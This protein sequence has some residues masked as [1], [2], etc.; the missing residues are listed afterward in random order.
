MVDTQSPCYDPAELDVIHVGHRD[1]GRRRAAASGS[2]V[3]MEIWT[4]KCGQDEW[5]V[6][7]KHM[8]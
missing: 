7:P 2:G 8:R 6:L 1:T 3:Q 4:C 5:E